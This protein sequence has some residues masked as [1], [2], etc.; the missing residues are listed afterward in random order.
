VERADILRLE[1]LWRYGG[2]YIDT[3]FECLKPIDE[4]L[5][6]VEFFTGLLKRA[7][8]SKPARVNNAI[9]GAGPG[10]PLLDRALDELR[11]HESG[12]PGASTSSS[13]SVAFTSTASSSRSC[14]HCSGGATRCTWCSRSRSVA[15]RRP[16]PG[17]STSFASATTSRTSGCLSATSPG[18]APRSR[19]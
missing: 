6:G 5:E 15:S 16:R 11:V 10:H 9:F 3:D 13:S 18:S 2:V 7:G 12:A 17:S 1:L 14:A 8:P 4:L 19:S